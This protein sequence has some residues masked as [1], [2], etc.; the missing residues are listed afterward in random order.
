MAELS[1]HE[2]I[3]G[4][5]Y[6]SI[7]NPKY[8]LMKIGK[9]INF[10]RYRKVKAKDALLVPTCVC[11]CA[12][13]NIEAL[14]K[15]RIVHLSTYHKATIRGIHGIHSIYSN[16]SLLYCKRSFLILVNL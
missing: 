8:A 5:I 15:C 14:F 4:L 1:T 16:K 11:V 7:H 10:L 12:L 6:I 9:E 2:Q 3:C 13:T